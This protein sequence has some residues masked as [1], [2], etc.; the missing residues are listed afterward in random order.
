[1]P[2]ERRQ[3]GDATGSYGDESGGSYEHSMGDGSTAHKTKVRRFAGR[4][5]QGKL[6]GYFGSVG[7]LPVSKFIP[8]RMV[9]PTFPISQ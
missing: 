7:H 2:S 4:H 3:A 5:R 6:M 1:M 9:A 8:S